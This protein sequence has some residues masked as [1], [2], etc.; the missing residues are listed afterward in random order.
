M[1]V[2]GREPVTKLKKLHFQNYLKL[3]SNSD[4]L[5]SESLRTGQGKVFIEICATSAKKSRVQDCNCCEETF[6]GT[7][8]RRSEE[9]RPK[10]A[11]MFQ[12]LS[13]H[14]RGC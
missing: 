1:S 12:I 4:G 13:C 9:T 5:I 6:R 11:A 3:G 7:R 10:V 2:Q 14:I 8:L